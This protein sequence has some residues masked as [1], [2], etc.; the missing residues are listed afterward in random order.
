MPYNKLPA[1]LAEE[2]YDAYAVSQLWKREG[3]QLPGWW[4]L[5]NSEKAA[6][7]DV[8]KLVISKMVRE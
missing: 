6:W 3:K 2:L 1:D 7:V 4:A 5:S 8:A